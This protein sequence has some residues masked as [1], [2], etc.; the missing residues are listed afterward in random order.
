MGPAGHSHWIDK[1]VSLAHGTVL[2]V[3][4]VALEA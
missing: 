1:A 3:T 4:N 2:S